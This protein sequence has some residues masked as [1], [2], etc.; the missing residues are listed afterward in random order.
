MGGELKTKLNRIHHRAEE[1]SPQERKAKQQIDQAVRKANHRKQT[2]LTSELLKTIRYGDLDVAHRLL[3][4]F[5]LV[6]TMEEISLFEQRPPQE[7]VAGA[8]MACTLR[9]LSQGKPYKTSS[10]DY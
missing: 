6:G 2:I 10:P 8:D 9:R 7:V 1:L 3:T 4:G 5:P